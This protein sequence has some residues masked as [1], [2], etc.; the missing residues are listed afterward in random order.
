MIDT[1]QHAID[2]PDHVQPFAELGLKPDEY[3]RIR[4]ILG[5]D[6]TWN[7]HGEIAGGGV[8]RFKRKTG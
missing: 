5:L 6:R 4:E 2:D 1:V 3:A 7:D 8:L